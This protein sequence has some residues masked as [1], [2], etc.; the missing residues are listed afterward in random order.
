[1][2]KLT[3]ALLSLVLASAGAH[4]ANG[5]AVGPQYDT[6]HAYVSPD[7]FDRLVASLIATFGGTTTKQGLAQI[8][9]TPSKTKTQLALTSAGTVSVIG[10]TTPIPFPF[11]A[12]RTGYL[13]TDIDAAEKAARAAGAEVLVA[14]FPDPIGR[15]LIVQWPGGVNM[16]FYVHT[17]PPNYPA[18]TT[19]PENR[20]YISKDAA[21]TFVRD[22]VRFS[23]GKIVSD[24]R[25]AAGVEIGLPGKSYR[26]VR[27]E[28][29][30]GKLVAIATDG[31][32][33]WPYG[34]ELTGYEVP[35]LAATL[36]KARA[37]GASVLVPPVVS[38]GRLSAM[39]RFPGGYIAEV[40]AMAR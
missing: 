9:P 6:T 39:V 30:F 11:G 16:Q 5:F 10:F 13:V 33:P 18:L 19:V 36:S 12:E 21:N 38:D 2:R 28:S 8:T 37:A 26:R 35:D 22:F 14:T 3:F 31:Q 34:R 15:D 20:V 25:A 24:D 40:H 29:G 1:M 17:T 7:D 27:V 23:A 4:A 32:I